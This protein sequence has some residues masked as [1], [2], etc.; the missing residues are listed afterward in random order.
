M[1]PIAPVAAVAMPVETMAIAVTMTISMSMGNV[2]AG[3]GAATA[4][5]GAL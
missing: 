3:F 4:R 5:T 2:A 1:P